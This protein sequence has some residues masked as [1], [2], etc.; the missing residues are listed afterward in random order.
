MNFLQ[1][2]VSFGLVIGALGMAII[3]VRNVAERK[4]EI[5]MMRAIG[6]PR[7][8]VMFAVLLE[9]FVL[10]II[11]LIIGIVNGLLIGYGL[12]RLS[13]TAV[14]V[15]WDTIAIYLGFITLVAVVAG[16]LPG[17]FAARIPASEALRYV[18]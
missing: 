15:P 10:G 17:W 9:L 5:G 4:R 12:S 7:G 8:Q 16:A 11:G 3:A 18:G 2:Y 1:I 13:D 14:I 6:F